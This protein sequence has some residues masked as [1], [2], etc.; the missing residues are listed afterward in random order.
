MRATTIEHTNRCFAGWA[1]VHNPAS[2]QYAISD[3]EAIST[4]C[5]AARS[6]LE[7]DRRGIAGPTPLNRMATIVSEIQFVA[8]LEESNVNFGVRDCIGDYCRKPDNRDILELNTA[9]MP[10]SFTEPST[11]PRVADF[12]GVVYAD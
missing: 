4:D 10:A 12:D 11:A 5:D 1:R 7:A 8:S 6:A 2:N 9:D 3:L